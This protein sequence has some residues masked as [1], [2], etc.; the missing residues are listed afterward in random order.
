MS[1]TQQQPLHAP[2]DVVVMAAYAPLFVNVNHRRWN[3]NLIV[4]DSAR[5]YGIPSYYVQKMFSEHRGTV[6]LPTE[7]TTVEVPDT[8]NGGAIGVG[9]SGAM[10]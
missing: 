2:I 7:V 4:F 1:S 8:Q 5:A 3:P 6:V 10:L 9:R